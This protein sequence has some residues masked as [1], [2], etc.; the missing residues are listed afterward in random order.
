VA[1][2]FA[3]LLTQWVEV[4]FLKRALGLE[5][6]A[7]VAH[8]QLTIDKKNIGLDAGEALFQGIEERVFVLKVVVGMGVVQRDERS[9]RPGTGTGRQTN[10]END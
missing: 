7:G 1:G 9:L 5:L 8:Q 10:G 2:V 3:R 4:E 6:I